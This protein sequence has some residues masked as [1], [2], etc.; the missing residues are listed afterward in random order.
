M[1]DNYISFGWVADKDCLWQG[2]SHDGGEVSTAAATRMDGS[3]NETELDLE[4][5]EDAC[6]H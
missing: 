3:I 5:H 4:D 6:H 1:G 2:A